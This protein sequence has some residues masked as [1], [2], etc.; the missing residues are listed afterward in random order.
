[1]YLI[2]GGLG[3]I[4]L[5]IAEYLAQ[6]VQARLVLVGR[7]A[8][9]E[10]EQ[11][12]QLLETLAP[13]EKLR[14]KLER[15]ERLKELGS[16]VL[17]I[18]ADVAD[19]D[20]MQAAIQRTIATFGLIHGVI[21]AAAVP[22]SGLIQMKTPEKATAVLS[23]KVQGLL[24]LERVLRD[25]ELDFLVLFSSMSSFT[26][27]GPGQ[28][29]YCAANA[30]LDAYARCHAT[31][32]RRI[33]AIDW[34][35]WQWD[36][37][38]DGL[39]GFPEVLQQY[40]RDVRKK[41]GITF[42]EGFEALNRILCRNLAQVVVS[43]Q[44]FVEM[45]EGSKHFSTR[46]LM[47]AVR[48]RQEQAT[49]AALRAK[50]TL[51]VSDD[52]VEQKI[53]EIWSDLLGV[54]QIDLHDNFFALGGHSLMGLQLLSRLRTIFQVHLPPSSLFEAPT[55]AELAI[56]IKLAL[57]TELEQ[58]HDDEAE[59]LVEQNRTHLVQML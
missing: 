38:A 28:V 30:F 43:T 32:Q 17:T 4:G 39:L 27:G 42:D 35:E 52:P 7:T 44:N 22:P 56:E 25:Q 24:T 53:G 49:P 45:V 16:E 9:P 18:A 23:P 6:K 54:E 51:V 26:G 59:Q 21:H 11:W 55:I 37:W 19:E 20:A 34:G 40:F 10:G 2:T 13:D 48:D 58:M 5:A 8:L 15:I 3:G 29:D 1:V 14:S 47:D 12:S 46:T 33:I 41:F 31:G 50:P 57:V 36:A